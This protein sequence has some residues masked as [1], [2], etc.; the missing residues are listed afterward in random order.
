[1][2]FLRVMNKLESNSL[3]YQK[4]LANEVDSNWCVFLMFVFLPRMNNMK[5]LHTVV[6]DSQQECET[7]HWPIRQELLPL[8][9]GACAE[10]MCW[11]LCFLQKQETFPF[12]TGAGLGSDRTNDLSWISWLTLNSSCCHWQLSGSSPPTWWTTPLHHLHN[13]TV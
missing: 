6:V 3:Y 10:F 9:D 2:F 4:Y 12:L 8:T 5:V 11:H 1:M 13:L 7:L